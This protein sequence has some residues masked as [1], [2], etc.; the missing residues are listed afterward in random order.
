MRV[1]VREEALSV[2]EARDLRSQL[3]RSFEKSKEFDTGLLAGIEF[4]RGTLDA[5]LH[6]AQRH[7]FGWLW[8]LG[9]IAGILALWLVVGLVRAKLD[10]RGCGAGGHFLPCL[11]GGMFGMAA[12]HWIYESLFGNRTNP[13]P[14]AH[15]SPANAPEAPADDDETV[16]DPDYAGAEDA[17]RGDF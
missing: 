16:Q 1:V 4:L 11:F 9:S 15:P 2:K 6:P 3:E 7:P 13:A 17:H 8:I 5:R 12:G 10:A 14:E